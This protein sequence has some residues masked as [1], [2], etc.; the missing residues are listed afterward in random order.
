[1]SENNEDVWSWKS[2]DWTYLTRRDWQL[3][4]DLSMGQ[5]KTTNI[6]V[7]GETCFVCDKRKLDWTAG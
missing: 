1:M 2:G 7:F 6:I 5:E 3:L 4:D